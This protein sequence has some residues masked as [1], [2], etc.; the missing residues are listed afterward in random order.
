[1]VLV[2][3]VGW[4]AGIAIVQIVSLTSAFIIGY[5]RRNDQTNE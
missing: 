3:F 2:G 1:M 4:A 5:H